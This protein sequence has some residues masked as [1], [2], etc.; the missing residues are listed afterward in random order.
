MIHS[1]LVKMITY[2]RHKSVIIVTKVGVKILRVY[3]IIL[4]FRP[5]VCIAYFVL[6]LN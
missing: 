1:R 4:I 5:Y 3:C 6:F 2:E